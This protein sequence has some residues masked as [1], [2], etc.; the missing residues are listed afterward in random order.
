V[1][2]GLGTRSSVSDE[3]SGLK[4][5]S[6]RKASVG[7]AVLTGTRKRTVENGRSQTPFPVGK[8]ETGNVHSY[9]QPWKFL[10]TGGGLSQ[11]G[12]TVFLGSFPSRSN[13]SSTFP[14]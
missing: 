7:L 9:V 8:R 10:L 11:M 14:P 6:E 1:V 2:L 4:S 13:R 5:D 3:R 12:D